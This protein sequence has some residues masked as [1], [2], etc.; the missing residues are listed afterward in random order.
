MWKFYELLWSLYV[1]DSR[2]PNRVS[3]SFSQCTCHFTFLL[4]REHHGAWIHP[5]FESKVQGRGNQEDKFND[6]RMMKRRASFLCTTCVRGPFA[7]LSRWKIC[8]WNTPFYKN[9]WLSHLLS[10]IHI[11]VFLYDYEGGVSRRSR[12]IFG[13]SLSVVHTV[14]WKIEFLL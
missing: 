11:L 14:L 5:P 3:L 10:K 1:Y 2:A 12:L 13:L 4:S 8:S 6:K 7:Q 9:D